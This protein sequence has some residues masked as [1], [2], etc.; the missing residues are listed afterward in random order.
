MHHESRLLPID[1]DGGFVAAT[2]FA[3]HVVGGEDAGEERVGDL[4][5]DPQGVVL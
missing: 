2:H 4:V 1:D 5:I 3:R